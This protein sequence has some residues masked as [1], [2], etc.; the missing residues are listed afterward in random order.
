MLFDDKDL[1]VFENNE[2]RQ[3]FKEILQSY[4]SQN[5]RATV[6][7]LYSFVI[8]DLFIKLQ[9]MANEGDK[10]ASKAIADI[11]AMIA[12][13][14]KYSLVENS[15]IQFFKENSPLYFDRFIEDIEYLKNCRNKCA[16][17]KVNDNSLFVPSDY[18]A[19]MLICS[20]YDNIFS[21]RAPFIMDLFTVAQTDVEN[22]TEQLY[23]IDTNGLDNSINRAI[24]NK[25]LSRMTYDSIKRSYK[26][27]IRLLWV[28]DDENCRKNALGLYAFTYAI[29]DYIVK[30]GFTRIYSEDDIQSTFSR[31][32]IDSLDKDEVRRN[33]LISIMIHV[34]AVMATI[35]SNDSL[36][37]YISNRV[38]LK[39]KG[40]HLYRNFYPRSD[41][42][43]Y[44]YYVENKELHQ[45]GYT[46]TL[47]EALKDCEDFNVNE[48]MTI[49]AD[50]IPAYSGFSI[51]DSYMDVFKSHIQDLSREAIDEIMKIY[52]SNNQ[53]TNRG[54]HS[55]DMAEIKKFLEPAVEDDEHI[56]EQ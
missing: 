17:L 1:K 14:E 13:D 11:N 38:L 4:Y 8:Y 54:R 55:S 15:V 7:L 44:S 16:H 52:R 45:A 32:T 29:A 36:F 28:S 26:T 48:F 46:E 56:D 6:V 43:M 40:L 20:M 35:R 30:E 22:Y 24:K 2:A 51:A 12:D 47:F 21:V 50:A 10:K 42:S 18:H 34:P 33:A 19:R 39:P 3:Y 31:I 23:S 9:T 5:Y 27:F 53:C 49:M 25:Y 41:K 37:E